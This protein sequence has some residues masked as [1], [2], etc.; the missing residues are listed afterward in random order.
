MSGVALKIDGVVKSFGEKKVLDGVSFEVK[1][2][3]I[4]GFVG[5]N[6]IGKT[7]LIKIV[8]NLLDCDLGNV[9]ILGNSFVLPSSRKNIFYL[10]EKFQPSAYLKGI[11]FLKFNDGFYGNFKKDKKKFLSDVGAMAESLYLD[12]KALNFRVS[13]YSK[14]MMQ[15]LGLISAFL[16]GADLI[17]LDEPMSGLDP[18]A[19]IGLKKRLL[20]YKDKGKSI[21]FSSHVLSDIDEICD[22]IAVLNDGQIIFQGS[23]EDFKGQQGDDNLEKAFLKAIGII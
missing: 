8:I 5:L 6:G 3:E 2:G 20:E 14:G 19:R 4:F 1:K 16:S 9:E 10:P 12:K 7:T 21:F 13:K 23:C 17:I 11:E 15:K 18:S 22:A